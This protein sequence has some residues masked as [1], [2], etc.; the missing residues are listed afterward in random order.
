MC[1]ASDLTGSVSDLESRGPTVESLLALRGQPPV[2]DTATAEAVARDLYGLTARAIPLDGERDRNFR[3]DTSDG[4]RLVLKFIDPEADEVVVDGQSAA[5]AHIAATAPLLPVP[6]VLGTRGGE[7]VG[8][9]V[10]SRVRLTSFVPGRLMQDVQAPAPA[11]LMRSVG[12]HVAHLDR[13]LVGFFH[14]ALA[15]P[16]AWDVR[17]A[18]A[19]LPMLA[20]VQPRELQRTLRAALDPLEQL[21]QR[22]R[23]LRSQAIHGDCHGRNLL[24]ND[25]GNACVGIIDLGD[26]IHAPLALELAVTMAELLTDG[27]ASLDELP[28]LLA[29]YTSL[30]PL[31]RA[32][33]EVLYDLMATRIA[34][35]VLIQVWRERDGAQAVA[36]QPAAAEAGAEAGRTLGAASTRALASASTALASASRVALDALA[37]RGRDQLTQQWLGAAGIE[38]VRVGRGRVVSADLVRRRHNA[39]GAN[40]ELSYD[41]PLHLV[42]GEGVWVYTSDAER[43]LDVY[44]NVPHVGHA[45]SSVVAAIANQAKRIA[46]N[47]RYLDTRIIEYVER[48]TET[49]PPD[50]DRESGA[51]QRA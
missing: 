35:G 4:R 2:V 11:G 42:R 16:I 12:N 9:A 48:L 37:S 15:Q 51:R 43:L 44:N 14:P 27:L 8:V 24:V 1:W 41:Q 38:S 34:V 36:P 21:L 28:E 49:L 26:M 13:A 19:L 25:A 23:G 47:T 17:R 39:L 3:L 45:H 6:R 46:S 22:M 33:V 30:L 5:L 50:L 29:G 20:H 18:H 31:E 10:S 32:D 40:A 7:L